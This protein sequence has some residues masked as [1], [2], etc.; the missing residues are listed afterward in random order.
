MGAQSIILRQ[1]LTE[2]ALVAGTWL[3]TPVSVD[4]TRTTASWENVAGA[5]AHSVT[6]TDPTTGNDLLEITAF[7]GK[8]NEV[9]VP[10]VVALPTTGMLNARVNAIGADFDLNDFSFDEDSSKL[11]G[12]AA[13]RTTIP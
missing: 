11:W 4:V 10:N 12:I 13:E 1:A 7:D 9:D 3:E 5:K 6:W 8:T 2:P